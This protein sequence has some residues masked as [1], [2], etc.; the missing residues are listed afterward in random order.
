MIQRQQDEGEARAEKE[1]G[2][3]ETGAQTEVICS[4][5]HTHSYIACTFTAS[6]I[7]TDAHID[8]GA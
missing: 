8:L 2:Q 1:E 6:T 5:T 4:G 3:G 7:Q